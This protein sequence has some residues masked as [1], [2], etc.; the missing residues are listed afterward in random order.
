M[1]E[2]RSRRCMWGVI[3]TYVG[4]F[5]FVRLFYSRLRQGERVTVSPGISE[6]K[7]LCVGVVYL[8]CVGS[9]MHTYLVHSS[10]MCACARLTYVRCTF[11]SPPSFYRSLYLPI[12][13]CLLLGS[14]VGWAIY[15]SQADGLASGWSYDDLWVGLCISCSVLFFFERPAQQ[16]FFILRTPP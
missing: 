8:A 3:T 16:A 6:A 5:S 4:W 7:R 1:G 12:V 14:R 2:E 11:F 13:N 10:R 9:Y 15:W